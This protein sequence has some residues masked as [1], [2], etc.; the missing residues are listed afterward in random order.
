MRNILIM[1][2]LFMG[3]FY[4]MMEKDQDK[5]K[6]DMKQENMEIVL[7]H[8]IESEQFDE[9]KNTNSK[10]QSG[11]TEAENKAESKDTEKLIKKKLKARLKK[12]KSIE[13]N[14]ERFLAYKELYQEYDGYLDPPETVYDKFTEEEIYLMQ[15]CIETECFGADFDSKCNIASV[16]LNRLEDGR[17]GKTIT[18]IITYPNQFAYGRKSI[19]EDSILALEYVSM[20][21]DTT[22]GA[23]YFHSNQTTKTFNGANFLFRDDVGHNFYK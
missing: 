20:F 16:I 23:L 14:K 7:A 3:S 19:E 13:N 17:F 18:D 9:A 22:K 21:G 11:I 12:I 5:A 4:I 2:L 1:A 8:E 15:R 10:K 6:N